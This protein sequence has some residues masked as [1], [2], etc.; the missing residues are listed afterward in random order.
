M[1]SILGSL[2]NVIKLLYLCCCQQ[3]LG[4]D[5][6]NH[7]ISLW[8]QNVE[9]C[10]IIRAY[11][12]TSSSNR[13][14]QKFWKAKDKIFNTQNKIKILIE[15]LLKIK[16]PII[17]LIY[18]LR[19]LQLHGNVGGGY[20]VWNKTLLQEI[21]YKDL[22]KIQKIIFSCLVIL[23]FSNKQDFASLF[24][25]PDNGNSRNRRMEE[26]LITKEAFTAQVPAALCGFISFLSFFT[27]T[28]HYFIFISF[29][30]FLLLVIM[31]MEEYLI[32]KLAFSAHGPQW[33]LPK[34]KEGSK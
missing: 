11:C 6:S 33:V 15:K 9:K 22:H 13:K 27:F 20:H 32:S 17:D 31:G 21:L 3:L 8:R 25:F 28:F 23:K 26:F 34:R 24:P 14:S 7:Y 10:K 18:Q 4:K 12:Q 1:W 19:L 5:I 30:L 16:L 2:H 29:C